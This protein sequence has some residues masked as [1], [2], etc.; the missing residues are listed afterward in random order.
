MLQVAMLPGD[1][2]QIRDHLAEHVT[3]GKLTGCVSQLYVQAC[4]S[5]TLFSAGIHH[6]S[7]VHI[8]HAMCMAKA[9]L[10]L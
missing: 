3:A 4:S 1:I 2:C 7:I 6:G 9:R 5:D 8:S 10:R